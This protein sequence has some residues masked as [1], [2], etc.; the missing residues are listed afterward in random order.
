MKTITTIL[1]TAATTALITASIFMHSANYFNM[2]SMTDFDVTDTGL[3]LYT[4]D[5]T[6]WYWER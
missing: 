1:I 6:G 3:M 2:S 5:G 4:E